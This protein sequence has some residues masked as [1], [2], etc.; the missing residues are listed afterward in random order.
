MFLCSRA[1]CLQASLFFLGLK[2]EGIFRLSGA[3]SEVSR[4]EQELNRPPH[5]GTDVDLSAF[6]IHAIT[7]VVK[8]YLRKLPEPVV[9]RDLHGHF[10]HIA[11]KILV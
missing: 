1:V 2:I 7:S 9:P 8:A 10:L 3:A 4:L 11:G 6:D 5:Y